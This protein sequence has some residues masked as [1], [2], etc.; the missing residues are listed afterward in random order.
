MNPHACLQNIRARYDTLTTVE[1]RIAD[2]I[3]LHEEEIPNLSTSELADKAQT[4]TSAIVRCCKSLG[5]EGY[6][7][8]KLALAAELSKN[9][10]LNYAPYIFPEDTSAQVMEKVFSANVKALHDTADQLNQTQIE[11][12]LDRLAAARHI[13]LYGVGTSASMVTEL[14]YRLMQLGYDAFAYTDPVSMRISTLNLDKQDVAFAIS[15]SGRT[16]PT[17]QAMEL[18]KESGAETICFTGFPDSPL[19]KLCSYSVCVCSDEVRY[20]VEAMSAKIAQL[21]LI[22]ALTTALS[23][24]HYDDTVQRAKKTRAL[25]DSIRLE[26]SR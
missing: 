12:I 7:Q 21:S 17:V 4:A 16:E 8:L 26:G 23:A 25:I 2:Y 24:R 11:H 9:R 13:C 10:Q 1:K 3:L 15:Y 19:A 20:P 14:Q 22:Y 18:A 5:F 6:P